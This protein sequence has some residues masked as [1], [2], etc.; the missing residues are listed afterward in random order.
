LN[1]D[2][3]F[4]LLQTLLTDSE[5][6]NAYNRVMGKGQYQANKKVTAFINQK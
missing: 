6:E 2:Q 3:E 4:E 5:K 1:A